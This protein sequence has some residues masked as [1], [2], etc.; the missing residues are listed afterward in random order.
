MSQQMNQ[1]QKHYWNKYLPKIWNKNSNPQKL[2][3]EWLYYPA[4]PFQ[5]TYLK[6]L[7]RAPQTSTYTP[8]L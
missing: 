8:C 4:I 2:N 6:E 1:A 3:E 5:V 7:K